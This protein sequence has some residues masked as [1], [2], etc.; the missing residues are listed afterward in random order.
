MDILKRIPAYSDE[1]MWKYCE[2][3]KN[4]VLTKKPNK[5]ALKYYTPKEIIDRV[6]ASCD[7]YKKI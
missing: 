5:D 3:L 4:I 6:V 1:M 7:Y 2:S